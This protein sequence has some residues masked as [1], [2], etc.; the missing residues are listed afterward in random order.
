MD[1]RAELI[2]FGRRKPFKPFRIKLSDGR[3]FSL[4]RP[5]R[6]GLGLTKVFVCSETALLA[7]VPLTDV[8]AIEALEPAA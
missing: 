7:Q 3:V 5:H 8:L 1:T 4:N 6:F 2:K